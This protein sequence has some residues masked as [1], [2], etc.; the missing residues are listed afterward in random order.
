METIRVSH[1]LVK[2]FLKFSSNTI[3]RFLYFFT[4]NLISNKNALPQNPA[5]IEQQDHHYPLREKN[6]IGKLINYS[7]ITLLFLS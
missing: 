1:L 7:A 5:D 3:R 6:Q 4:T 2:T